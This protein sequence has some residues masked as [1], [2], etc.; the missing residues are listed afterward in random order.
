VSPAPDED[1]YRARILELEAER[2]RLASVIDQTSD[3]ILLFSTRGVCLEANDTACRMLDYSREEL[4]CLNYLD[5]VTQE[6][7]AEDPIR[8]DALVRGDLLLKERRMRRRDGTVITVEIH[9]R[10]LPDARLL[11]VLRDVTDRKRAEEELENR[12]AELVRANKKLEA[13]HRE[14]DEFIAMVSHELRTPLVTGLGYIEMLLGG[15]FGPISEEARARMRVARS[16]LGR[17][18]GLIDDILSYSFVKHEMLANPLP[19]P[20][21]LGTLLV[22]CAGEF[23]ARTRRD[24]E[25][26]ELLAPGDRV[27]V[28]ADR[29][30]IRM[31][32]A[33]LLDNVERH[34]GEGA[35]VRIEVSAAPEDEEDV[36]VII[37]DN[38]R[39][40]DPSLLPRVFEPFVKSGTTD[41]GSG[42]GL[43]IVRSIL[44]AHASEV[45]LESKPEGG[46]RVTFSLRRSSA[47]EPTRETRRTPTEGLRREP[48][49]ASIFIV[50]DDNDTLDLLRLALET[51]GYGVTTARSAEEALVRVERGVH[52][53]FLLDL[54]LPGLDGVDLCRQ[55]KS[56][57]ATAMTPV[58]FLTARAEGAARARAAAAGCDGYIVKP[59]SMADLLKTVRSAIGLAAP[60]APSKPAA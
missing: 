46:T 5:L 18:S 32:V 13:L 26:V 28:R 19:S 36:R 40:L 37:A 51:A 29:E 60:S 34:A 50:D 31:V 52:D 25:S 35:R 2:D 10:C 21:D 4:L 59:I 16:N 11:G 20:F 42:L 58:Y 48:G 7:V 45:I 38:G 9:A 56:N 33:N 30:L 22:E 55:L 44:A 27:F 15:Q 57:A 23:L 53:L 41:A 12:H 39:G 17:L 14:K 8:L 6:C 49:G 1:A 54:T 24:P 43:T 47:P 3:G